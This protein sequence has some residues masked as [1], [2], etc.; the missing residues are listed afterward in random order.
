MSRRSGRKKKRTFSM[1]ARYLVFV[2]AVFAAFSYM[3]Y[4]A[5]KLQVVDGAGYAEDAN[6]SSIKTIPITGMR[7]MITDVNSVI[8]AKS[9]TVYNVTFQRTG[10][11]NKTEDYFEFTQSILQTLDI[12]DQILTRV[13]LYD[14]GCNMDISAAELSSSV[15]K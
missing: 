8:L 15:M 3:V 5:Y 2:V 7:G 13:P 12:L 14:F 6:V 1:N 10:E 11:E 4:G 9:E